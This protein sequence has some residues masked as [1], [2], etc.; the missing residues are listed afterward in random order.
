MEVTV[1]W[2]K[3]WKWFCNN[4]CWPSLVGRRFHRR[5]NFYGCREW[6]DEEYT[7]PS[8]KLMH[9]T[10]CMDRKSRY[11]DERMIQA[12]LTHHNP[13]EDLA[14][15]FHFSSVFDD[16]LCLEKIICVVTLIIVKNGMNECEKWLAIQDK[17]SIREFSEQVTTSH[18]LSSSFTSPA[19]VCFSVTLFLWFVIWSLLMIVLCTCP[20][21]FWIWRYGWYGLILGRFYQTV[22][23]L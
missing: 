1:C 13:N 22:Q 18:L 15:E 12:F 3:I 8:V 9:K 17:C 23:P 20:G 7:C 19:T 16:I 5:C 4:D 2:M 21:E 11:S 14:F 6:D 10:V